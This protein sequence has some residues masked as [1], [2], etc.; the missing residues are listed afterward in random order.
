M[1][2]G[3]SGER[4]SVRTGVRAASNECAARVGEDEST[5]C[6]G[7]R[8]I[9]CWSTLRVALLGLLVGGVDAR[10]VTQ[11]PLALLDGAAKLGR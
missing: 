2:L 1:W 3:G 4:E 9:H 11:K 10:A 6:V 8:R 7:E 5:A